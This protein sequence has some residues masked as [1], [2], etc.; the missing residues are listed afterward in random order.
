MVES[1]CV[2]TYMYNAKILFYLGFEFSQMFS[3][4][5]LGSEKNEL[6]VSCNLLKLCTCLLIEFLLLSGHGL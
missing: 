2:C 1:F 5:N 4:L 6:L 3:H